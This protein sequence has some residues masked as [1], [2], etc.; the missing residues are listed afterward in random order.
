[1]LLIIMARLK[2]DFIILITYRKVFSKLSEK[3]TFSKNSLVHVR[4]F[5]V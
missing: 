4:M 1:M 3:K 5:K 2:I